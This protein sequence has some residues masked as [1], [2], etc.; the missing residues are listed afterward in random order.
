MRAS[1]LVALLLLTASCRWYGLPHRDV[2]RT[3]ARAELVGTWTMTP[4]SLALLVRDGYAPAEAC[5]HTIELRDDGT[6]TFATVSTVGANGKDVT[7]YTADGAWELRRETPS[8]YSGPVN[9][10][11]LTLQAEGE[12]E[13]ES[14]HL[15]EDDDG[16]VLWNHW[17]DPDE[18]EYIDYRRAR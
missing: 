16:L 9:V 4:E 17:V 6:V 15:A 12:T 11:H 7:P 18:R 5:T 1:L 8:S 2:D 14:F 10:L 13:W 3:V